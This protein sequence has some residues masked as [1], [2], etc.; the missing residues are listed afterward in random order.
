MA[1]RGSILQQEQTEPAPKEQRI[2]LLTIFLVFIKIGAFT[3]GGGYAILPVIQREVVTA[4]KWVD[5]SVFVDMLVITQSIPGQLALNSAIQIGILLRG[6]PGGAIAALAVTIPSVVIIL[7]IAAFFF[8]V[9]RELVVVQALFYG[10][11]PAVVALIAAAAVNL[12]RGGVIRGWPSTV[13]AAAL[14]AVALLFQVH[15]IGILLAG[16][17]AGLILFRKKKEV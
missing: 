14:L 8:T 9:Y 15:P 1:E 13:L 3:F 6:T 7:L 11:R 12:A 16:G 2:S 17:I 4:R 10:L 5:Q